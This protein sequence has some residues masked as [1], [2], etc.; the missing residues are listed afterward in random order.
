M[1]AQV[2]LFIESF[3]ALLSLNKCTIMPILKCNSVVTSSAPLISTS[4]APF[5]AY[6]YRSQSTSIGVPPDEPSVVSSI[7]LTNAPSSAPLD[8]T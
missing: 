6:L 5:C 4:N 3:F 1:P 7:A 2:H 8:E